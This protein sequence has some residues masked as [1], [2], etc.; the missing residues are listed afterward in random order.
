MGRNFCGRAKSLLYVVE[1]QGIYQYAQKLLRFSL[2]PVGKPAIFH[3]CI[4]AKS[5][6]FDQRDVLILDKQIF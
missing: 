2:I 4:Y 5:S 6:S 1:S 3:D